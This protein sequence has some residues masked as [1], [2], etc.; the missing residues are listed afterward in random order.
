MGQLASR[1]ADS[2]RQRAEE[3]ANAV[4]MQA[5]QRAEE[6]QR[7]GQEGKCV[8]VCVW[9]SLSASGILVVSSL[10]SVQRP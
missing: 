2:E 10:L 7:K 8:C 9:S 6:E 4:A 5:A 3:T 1:L